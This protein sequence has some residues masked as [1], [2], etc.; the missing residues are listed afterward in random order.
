ME[1]FSYSDIFATKGVEYLIIIAFL[2]MLIP[3]AVLLNKQVKISRQIQKALGVLSDKIL[4]IPQGLFYSRNHTW[5]FMEQ[6]G[7]AKVGLDDLLLH[8]TGE[9]KFS[10]L[11]KPGDMISK[12]DLLTEICQDG[13]L[14]QLFSPVSGKIMDTNSMLNERP[15]ILNEDPYGKG[16]IYKIK[17]SNWLAEAKSCY[18][19]E[20]ATNWSAKELERFK[21]FLAV[22]MRNYTH[23]TSMVIL[24]DGGELCDH[25]LV[26]LPEEIWKDFQKE[27]LS[28]YRLQT[29]AV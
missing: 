21:D 12:G 25:S 9:V 22:T 3:F 14:L 29:P 28:L 15:E 1:G 23:E 5:M 11:K 20:E 2:A 17:P 16:W 24:Q 18:F 13:K 8:I 26:A 6:S 27:F 19:A 10:S 4:R 7:S